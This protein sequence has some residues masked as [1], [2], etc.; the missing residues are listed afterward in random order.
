MK[1]ILKV[2]EGKVLVIDEAYR[3]DPGGRVGGGQPDSYKTVVIN[4]IVAEVQNTSGED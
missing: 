1:R 4:T 3:M 2:L